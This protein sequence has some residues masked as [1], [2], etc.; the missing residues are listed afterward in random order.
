MVYSIGDI[1]AECDIPYKT[2]E[3][4]I[5]QL[6]KMPEID[7]QS[8]DWEVICQEIVDK[9]PTAK[10]L[11]KRL[12][13]EGISAIP[14][15]KEIVTASR[16]DEERR[17]DSLLSQKCGVIGVLELVYKGDPEGYWIT[18]KQKKWL[19]ER[20]IDKADEVTYASLGYCGNKE[21][22]ELARQFLS[23]IIIVKETKDLKKIFK[24]PRLTITS[25][26]GWITHI[27]D[28]PLSKKIRSAVIERYGLLDDYVFR[29][30]HSSNGGRTS[31]YRKRDIEP[32]EYTPPATRI[33]PPIEIRPEPTTYK[34]RL[35]R[36]TKH[37]KEYEPIVTDRVLSEPSEWEGKLGKMKT[38]QLKLRR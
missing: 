30:A 1:S 8:L 34:L 3:Q 13:Q 38:Q 11:W 25:E 9:P 27:N 20:L 5:N 4:V 23:E 26:K 10:I 35:K 15:E 18:P 33:R 6:R 21:K 19:K 16:R 14:T 22:K 17:V 31:I 32:P 36:Q 28:L 29:I 12:E 2:V 7:W 37:I 24:G